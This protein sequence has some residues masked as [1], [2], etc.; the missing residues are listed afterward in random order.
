MAISH[1]IYKYKTN[2]IQNS[3]LIL[4]LVK[5]LYQVSP[6][7]IGMGTLNVTHTQF[8]QAATIPLYRN[9]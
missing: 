1:Y 3:V 8:N 2:I 6:Q 7:P 9:E 4:S 5:T